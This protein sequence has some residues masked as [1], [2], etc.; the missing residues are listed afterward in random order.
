MMTKNE[1]LMNIYKIHTTY[2]GISRIRRN[3]EIEEDVIEFYKS[4]FL[5]KKSFI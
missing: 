3:L 5:N 2:L 4:K 1:S